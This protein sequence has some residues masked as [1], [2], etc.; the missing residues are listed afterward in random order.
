[1]TSITGLDLP[2]LPSDFAD[3]PASY[4][5]AITTSSRLQVGLSSDREDFD[6]PCENTKVAITDILSALQGMNYKTFCRSSENGFALKVNPIKYIDVLVI[7]REQSFNTLNVEVYGNL[8]AASD[9]VDWIKGAYNTPLGATIKTINAVS[10]ST[11]GVSE[12]VVF[13]DTKS[14][15]L[16]RDSFYPWFNLSLTEYI[17]R[18][19]ESKEPILVL[20]GPPGCGKSTFLRTIIHS[21]PYP[22]ML[23]Y[24]TK[25]VESSVTLSHFYDQTD[26]ILAYE[27]IDRH[28]D[29][30]D[31]GNA[32]MSSILN[33]AEGVV[34]RP[35]KKIIFSTNLPSIERINPAL[36][37]VGRCYDIIEF[38][39]LTVREAAAV[40]EDLGF[41][42]RNFSAKDAWSLA[43][44][45]G[46]D[47]TSRQTINRF[48][49]KVGFGSN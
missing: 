31:N 27:D 5:R 44:I 25:V 22:T 45:L 17:K 28:L 4:M 2:N 30:R 34:E 10:E 46:E 43:E 6:I 1:M 23:A 24:N 15:K 37:R 21:G 48:A 13:A 40:R 8:P 26:R 29:R 41:A 38:R 32:L 11:G 33:Q 47:Q 49:K 19:M 39:N 12:S 16:G 7:I 42:P 20:F 36:L 9:F 14:A 18:F 35:D 3:F